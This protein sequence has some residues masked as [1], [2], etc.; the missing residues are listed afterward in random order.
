L[1]IQSL[2]VVAEEERTELRASSLGLALGQG[3]GG[4]WGR[5]EEGKLWLIPAVIVLGLAV[6]GMGD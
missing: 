4:V 3:R 6:A 2:L 5:G 1:D